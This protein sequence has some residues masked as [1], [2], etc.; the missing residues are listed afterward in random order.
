MSHT[1]DAIGLGDSP[2]RVAIGWPIQRRTSSA[3]DYECPKIWVSDG[4]IQNLESYSPTCQRHS[5]WRPAVV[6]W[7]P[8]RA[9]VRVTK[10]WGIQI[11]GLW[12]DLSVSGL[13]I[14]DVGLP[15]RWYGDRELLLH[16]EHHRTLRLRI[17]DYAWRLTLA[18]IVPCFP[19]QFEFNFKVSSGWH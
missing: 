7:S 11:T 19:F 4:A 9:G 1:N 6:E 17:V 12:S 14:A 18:L 3:G 15:R 2:R 13:T 10:G 16:L 5:E 8:C